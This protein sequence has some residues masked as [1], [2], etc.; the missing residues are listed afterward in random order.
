MCSL[1]VC[2]WSQVVIDLGQAIYNI[3]RQRA[4][5]AMSGV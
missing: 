3:Y 5:Y 2:L 1:A 4:V